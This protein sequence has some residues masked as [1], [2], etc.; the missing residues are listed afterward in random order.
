MA[1]SENTPAKALGNFLDM[2]QQ[3]EANEN[4]KPSNQYLLPE[5]M[6][7]LHTDAS[8]ALDSFHSSKAI[9]LASKKE[10]V[11]TVKAVKDIS[12]RVISFLKA[13]G[14]DPEKIEQAMAIYRLIHG[15]KAPGNVEPTENQPPANGEDSKKKSNRQG[16]QDS[17]VENFNKLIKVIKTEPLYTPNEADLKVAGL[18]ALVGKFKTDDLAT[19]IADAASERARGR[20]K[21]LFDDPRKGV[22]VVMAG[23]KLYSKAAF[24]SRS[25]E[26]ASL[27]K[28]KF[29]RVNF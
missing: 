20:L 9:M 25:A 28:I 10:R 1:T 19:A 27:S 8:A 26:Y 23:V 29:P 14:A 24:G 21:N 13:C 15:Y 6:K 22:N 4:Y 18:E 7:Q 12:R 16:S 5:Q 3:V 11:K 2:I 17:L